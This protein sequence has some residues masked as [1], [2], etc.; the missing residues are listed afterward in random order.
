[1]MLLRIVSIV[2]F[3]L[4]CILVLGV[5]A[6]AFTQ[7]YRRARESGAAGALAFLVSAIAIVST[8]GWLGPWA[9]LLYLCAFPVLGL[10]CARVGT[11]KIR[12]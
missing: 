3:V 9:F 11:A 10:L 8:I 7:Q 4:V 5:W 6:F 12:C 1:M 2:A